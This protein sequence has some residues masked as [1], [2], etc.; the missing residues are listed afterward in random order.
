MSDFTDARARPGQRLNT[1]TDD[2]ALFLTEFG[3]LVLQ[4]W[5]ESNSYESLTYTRNI[6]QGKSD[7]FPI[8]GRKRDAV[9]HEPGEMILGGTIEHND[10]E[11]TVDKLVV[12]AVFVADIDRLMLHYDVMAPYSVQLGQSLSTAYDRRVAILHIAASRI[13]TR[14]YGIGKLANAGGG[15]LPN[16]YF[17]ANIFTDPS[18]MEAAAFAAVGYIKRWDVG[19]G[20]L[21]YMMPWAQQLLLAKYSGLDSRQWT[22]SG[23]RAEGTVGKLAGLKVDAT[24]HIPRTNLTTGLAK[25]Q[26]DYSATMGHISNPMAVGTLSLRGLKVAMKDQVER[27]GTL[28]IAS[29]VNGHGIL[30]A[31][32]SFEVAT[33]DITGV[34]GANH[35]DINT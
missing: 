10:V 16:G 20:Q 11:I 33:S 23:N 2:R 26:G 25:F 12:D 13:V 27:Q 34:R 24:N 19:G 6:T 30:R 18:A 7:T 31:E 9:E 15:P 17:D 5:E 28:L 8:I 32:C 22:G 21:T 1:G 29:K 35:P 4:A 14:P 3:D